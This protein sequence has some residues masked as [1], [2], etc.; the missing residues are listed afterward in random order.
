M[1]IYLDHNATTRP[2]PRVVE[3]VEPYL[4]AR[5]GNAAS[6]HPRG[7]AAK[8]AVDAA[9]EQVAALVGAASSRV[10]W[11]SGATEAVNQVI[12]SAASA[13]R[14]R[15]RAKLVYSAGEHKAVLDTV[16]TCEARLGVEAV[17]APLR[18]SGEVDYAALEAFVDENTALVAVMAANNETGVL[19]D[20]DRVAEIAHAA[21]S[22]YLCDGTQ[23]IGKLP[24]DVGRSE[25]DFACASAHKLYGLQGAGALVFGR[26]ARDWLRPLIHGGGHQDGLR[27]GTLNVPGI[28]GFGEAAHLAQQALADQEPARLAMLRDHLETRLGKQVGAVEVHGVDARRLPNTVS[29]RIPGVDGEALIA[30]CPEVAMASGSACTSAVPSPSHVLRAMGVEDTVAEESVRL[31]LGR[32]TREAELDEGVAR[33]AGAAERLREVLA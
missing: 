21:G 31:S 3:A 5:F 6:P 15:G 27:S 33:I 25:I 26:E 17:E 10:V 13:G 14:E 20:I 29:L 11:T 8:A 28:V 1:E 30:N 7:R 22:L 24:F 18:P 2:D 19:N 16:E 4:S 9:R 32:Y 23:Q 12:C